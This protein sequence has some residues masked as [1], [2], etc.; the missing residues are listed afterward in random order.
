MDTLRKVVA[1]RQLPF[2]E[3]TTSPITLQIDDGLLRSLNVMTLHVK[4]TDPNRETPKQELAR[5][6]EKEIRKMIR[7]LVPEMF[8]E[9][10]APNVE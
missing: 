9:A 8:P 6:V 4:F 1:T 2:Q 5:R 7:R 3:E 10:E